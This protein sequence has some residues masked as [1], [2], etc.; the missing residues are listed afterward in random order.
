MIIIYA[1][2]IW[3]WMF[4]ALLLAAAGL[5]IIIGPGPKNDN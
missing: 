2:I 4:L 3:G 1:T 5:L